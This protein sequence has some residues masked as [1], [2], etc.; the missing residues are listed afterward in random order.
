MRRRRIVLVVFAV[1]ALVVGYFPLRA[2]VFAPRFDVPSIAATPEHKDAALLDRAW[3][4]PVA[5]TYERRVVFQSN[6]SVCGP[7]SVANVLRSLGDADASQDRVLEGTGK[8]RIGLCIPGVTLDELAEIVRQKTSK[9]VSVVRGITIDE[10]RE[11]LLRSNDP[12]RR[13]IVNFH[14]GMLFGK[15]V[16]HHSPIAGYLAAEDLVL[17]LDVNGAFGPWLVATERLFRAIDT[18]DTSAD[19]KRGLIVLE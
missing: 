7:A 2:T 13:Y 12:T 14:R 4:L 9:K 10:L 17:V 15:G 5:R 11:H 6:G 18:V 16:G 19:K 8:C 1:I 3:E